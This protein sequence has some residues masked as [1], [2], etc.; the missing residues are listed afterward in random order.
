MNSHIQLDENDEFLRFIPAGIP[1]VWDENN[2]CS[3]FAL[4]ADG[5]A[6]QFKVFSFYASA[7]PAHNPD[8]QEVQ[9]INPV[10]VGNEWVQQWEVIDLTPEQAAEKRFASD[11]AR[12]AK[13]TAVKD[14]LIAY[15]AADN[16]SRVRSGVWTVEQLAGLMDDPDVAAANAYMGILAFELAAEALATAQTP[17]LTQEIRADWIARLE[18]HFYLEG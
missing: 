5:K 11:Q 16:M 1:I 7:P 4:E 13:R 6:A 12:Y 14:Q 18:A 17:L 15:M 3:A 8:T 10:K 9:E 2:Y